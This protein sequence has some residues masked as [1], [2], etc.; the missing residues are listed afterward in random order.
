MSNDHLWKGFYLDRIDQTW[1]IFFQQEA[2]K[3]YFFYLLAKIDE[4]YKNYKCWPRKE[5]IFRLFREI[6][7]NKIKVVILGQDPY[8]LP[9][10]ADGL[11]FSTRKDKYMPASL[12]NIFLELSQ[13]LNCLPPTKGNLLPWVK[14]G[15]FLLNTALTV[16][17][18]QALSH[19]KLWE[20]FVYSLL[21]YLNNYNKEIIWVFWGQKARKIG[22]QCGISVTNNYVLISVH[23]SPY[24][25]EYG[26]F[27]SRP[28]SKINNLLAGLRKEPVDWLSV[29]K[30][31]LEKTN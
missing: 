17:D 21:E 30:P 9:E 6:P 5:N 29:A 23:P 3:D 4:E 22:E 15:I 25:A 1:N 10:V 31:D 24:S 12:K 26:F 20:K 7:L 8:H 14:E 28:F 13:D 27:G 19:V 11:A 16:K 2:K 18:G